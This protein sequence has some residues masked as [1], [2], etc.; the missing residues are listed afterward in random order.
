MRSM[1]KPLPIFNDRGLFKA[2]IETALS[3]HPIP[4]APLHNLAT[5]ATQITSTNSDTKLFR[6][7]QETEIPGALKSN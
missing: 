1:F 7:K 3:S 2:T 4:F 5:Q 6:K